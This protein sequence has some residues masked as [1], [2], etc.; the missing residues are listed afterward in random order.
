MVR[1]YVEVEVDVDAEPEDFTDEELIKELQLRG[2]EVTVDSNRP[3]WNSVA[4][5]QRDYDKHMAEQRK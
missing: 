1:K 4:D 2:Y 5:C 3:K